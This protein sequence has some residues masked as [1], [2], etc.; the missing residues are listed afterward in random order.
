MKPY[1]TSVF[2]FHRDLRLEDNISLCKAAELSETVIPLFV[3]DTKQITKENDYRSVPAI[4]FMID[5]L[6]DLDNALQRRGAALWTHTGETGEVLKQLIQKH[7]VSA[8]FSNHDY[9]PFAVRRD[10]QL[11][12]VCKEQGATWH[13]SHDALL[14]PPGTVLTQQ[15]TPYKVFTPFFHQAQTCSVPK[16]HPIGSA[17]SFLAPPQSWSF[18]THTKKL[19]V[20]PQDKQIAGGRD[21]ALT[22]LRSLSSFDTYQ[23]TRDVPALDSTTHL[24]AHNKF[25]SVSI[26]EVYWAVRNALGPSHTLIRELYWRDFFYH[27]AV[28]FPH[29]F[30]KEFQEQYQSLSW[31]HSKKDMERWCTGTTGFP[32][33]DA[34]M[35][36]LNETGFMHNRVRMIVASFLTKDLRIDW[37]WGEQYFATKLVDYDPCVN[38]GS[39]QWAASTGCDAQPYFRI[40]NP[41]GQQKKYDPDC[42]YIKKWIPELADLSPKEIHDLEKRRS[43]TLPTTTYPDPMVD[44][45]EAR[46]ATLVWFRRERS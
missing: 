6:Q 42:D 33:V 14:N 45:S 35:R 40:F 37:R 25:G 17:A 12:T 21:Q 34:G 8:V 20:P 3:F 19:D 29:V 36:Q 27:V 30:G 15:G 16:T 31:R 9:T 4:R 18:A 39:W 32:I 5:C 10:T 7:K 1:K 26:R 23:K 22:I 13:Q 24:S 11:A 46:K 41:W 2:L 28:A 43:L 38:N 44:H